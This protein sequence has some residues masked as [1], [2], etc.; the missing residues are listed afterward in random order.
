MKTIEIRI[1]ELGKAAGT[2][3][4]VAE[5]I[6]KI[7]ST[8]KVTKTK[9][10]E[11]ALS[12]EHWS[13]EKDGKLK[14]YLLCYIPMGY[15]EGIMI[16]SYESRNGCTCVHALYDGQHTVGLFPVLSEKAKDYVEKFLDEVT[17]NFFAEY[18][19]N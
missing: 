4:D 5:K 18:N 15:D 12:Y 14:R 11:P 1:P 6:E 13:D 17:E 16:G 8:L 3:A 19:K 7:A 10:G 9:D 2:T